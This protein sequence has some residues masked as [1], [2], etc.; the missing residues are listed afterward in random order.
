[1]QQWATFLRELNIVA[2]FV[3]L[4]FLIPLRQ[5]FDWFLSL[6]FPYI[7]SALCLL[8]TMPDSK[9]EIIL[10]MLILLLGYL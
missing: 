4:A 6:P 7:A 10:N 2:A 1:M 5:D 8:A 9:L 3:C